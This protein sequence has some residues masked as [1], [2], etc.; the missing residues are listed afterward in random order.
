MQQR[1]NIK[2]RLLSKLDAQWQ[3]LFNI[4]L[5]RSK[6]VEM[7]KPDEDADFIVIKYSDLAGKKIDF[8]RN[9]KFIV[10]SFGDVARAM[11][12][13][14]PED[15]M[16]RDVTKNAGA[17]FFYLQGEVA[18]KCIADE[19]KESWASSYRMDKLNTGS[20]IHILTLPLGYCSGSKINLFYEDNDRSAWFVKT[21][22]TNPKQ[23]EYD[24]CWIGAESSMDRKKMFAVL[25]NLNGSHKYIINKCSPALN[26]EERR[27]Q[28]H[29][30]NKPVPYAQYLD[31]H[32]KSKVC[33][34]ANGLGMWNYKDSEFLANNCFVLRQWHKNLELNPFTPKDGKH[35][36]VFQTDQVAEAID[37]YVKEDM[38]RERICDAGHDYFKWGIFGGWADAYAEMFIDYLNGKPEAFERIEY[39]V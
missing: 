6:R 34:S 15:T 20:H 39:H 37:Y 35:W 22:K 18:P 16:F 12:G 1:E 32:R 9:R 26:K 30:D 11:L 28:L 13:L 10:L 38:E 4:Y 2:C 29:A 14:R 23:Y 24:W 27:K 33:I 25:D 5:A 7:V 3:E 36:A 19:I 8:F 17:V 21:W 31:F